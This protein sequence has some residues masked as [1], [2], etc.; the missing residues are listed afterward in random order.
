MRK[1]AYNDNDINHRTIDSA[2]GHDARL[3]LCFL[4]EGTD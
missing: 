2:A 3:S 4:R 1:I